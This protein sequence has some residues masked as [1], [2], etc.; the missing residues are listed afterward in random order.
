M[1]P[2]LFLVGIG[3]ILLGLIGKIEYKDIKIGT[4]NRLV[5]VIVGVMGVVF[6]YWALKSYLFPAQLTPTPETLTPT[7]VSLPATPTLAPCQFHS[8]PSARQP[9]PPSSL[10][11]S[12]TS[13]AQ[14]A[15]GINSGKQSRT[16]TEG[17]AGQIPGD[18]SLWLL[19]YGPDGKYYPQCNQASVTKAD[20]TLQEEWSMR[21]YL[22]ADCKPYAL[23]LVSADQAATDFL[24]STMIDWQ[25]SNSYTGLRREELKPYQI[26]ELTSVQVETGSCAEATATP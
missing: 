16:A 24:L 17:T 4:E 18:H 6:V 3:L 8:N 2:I 13:P 9:F 22:G 21:T 10:T 14:C 1:E 12:I 11:G 26:Q 5:R 15:M 23:V 7:T 20:C 19:V 25:N